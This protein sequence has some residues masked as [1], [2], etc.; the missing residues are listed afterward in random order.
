ME[1]KI[2]KLLLIIGL[3]GFFLLIPKL[4]NAYIDPG[5]G[6]MVAS[7]L[8]V[9]VI[10]L[11]SAG[12]F[13][14]A[15]FIKPI[16]C[17]L[18]KEWVF[19]VGKT[20]LLL[21]YGKQRPLFFSAIILVLIVGAFLSI[22]SFH[23][24]NSMENSSNKSGFKKVLVFGIDG[25]DTRIAEFL[26]AQG[27]L[28]NFKKLS[29][30]GS[31]NHLNT[32]NPPIS[33]VVWTAMATGVNP[34][35]NNIFDF[36]RFDQK[37]LLPYLSILDEQQGL[38]GVNYNSPIKSAP[39]W[40]ILKDDNIFSSVLHWPVTF[41]AE[42]VNGKMLSGLGVPDSRGYLNSYQRYTN[43][44]V[45]DSNVQKVEVQSNT[46]DGEFS[47]PFK[48]GSLNFSKESFAV[49]IENENSAKLS[50]QDKIYDLKKGQW[51]DWISVKFKQGFGRNTETIFKIFPES[52]TPEFDIF[53]TSV[54]FDP[55]N[56]AVK[57]S[58]PEN[59]SK[60]L[61]D[62]I[63]IFYTL[64]MPEDAKAVNDK[65]LT[66]VA[67]KMQI[68]EI[69]QER[70]K[71]FW[72]EYGNFLKE[73]T[74]V[75]ATV[76]DEFDRFNHIFYDS[77]VVSENDKIKSIG[78]NLEKIYQD[79]DKM[80]GEILNKLPKDSALI[81]VSDHGFRPFNRMVNLNTWLLEN[82]YLFLKDGVTLDKADTLYKN[83]DWSKTK[84]YSFG[85]SSINL[86]MKN[87]EGKG[88]VGEEETDALLKEII[89]KLENWI[90]T[91]KNTNVVHQVYKKEDI[92][93]GQFIGTAGDLIVGFNPPYRIDWE[94]P[95][96]GFAMQSLA[97]N[98]RP[99]HADHIFDASYVPGVIFS[100]FK[101]NK[102]NPS[103]LDIAPTILKLLNV[104]VPDYFDGQSLLK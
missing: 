40:K 70:E 67:L 20:K 3:T 38:T 83:I 72:D 29:E 54:Q 104:G 55:R 13:L 34:G 76:F 94:N 99:W 73:K 12:S 1:K 68:D 10:A 16:W 53:A 103:V 90:D 96:G 45:V 30:T 27:K 81:V 6:G 88:I 75:F 66:P 41:P 87:R 95:V 60:D 62:K 58:Y 32:I 71:M 82:K 52:F 35:K 25:F 56:P 92:Y 98:T 51:S 91:E 57:I 65:N 86:N 15:Y 100:N 23:K 59:Y 80:L 97:D 37:K 11:M 14:L 69:R 50:V 78:P 63:G 48:V 93:K 28:P 77:E 4:A 8:S 22:K 47:G 21:A 33:P 36:I 42:A 43:K 24:K 7:F 31:Y 61:A 101:L 39:F 18:K 79:K 89:G 74:G 19:S 44:D 46:V 5:T 49:N 17:F 64:G 84:A 26:I 102:N 85:Y 9:I 2:L